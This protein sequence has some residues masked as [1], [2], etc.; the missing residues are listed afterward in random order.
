MKYCKDCSEYKEGKC[1]IKGYYVSINANFCDDY[2]LSS[3]IQRKEVA[4]WLI[5]QGFVFAITPDGLWMEEY[6]F[7]EHKT[8]DVIDIILAWETKKNRV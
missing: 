1:N 4:E 6:D 7:T 5:T 2:E 8:K 3:E